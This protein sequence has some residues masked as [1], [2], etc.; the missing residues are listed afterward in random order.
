MKKIRRRRAGYASGYIPPHKRYKQIKLDARAEGAQGGF[1][2]KLGSA[3]VSMGSFVLACI[4]WPF[5]TI[6]NALGKRPRRTGPTPG[7]AQEVTPAAAYH[8]QPTQSFPAHGGIGGKLIAAALALASIAGG[9]FL[10]WAL[11][12]SDTAMTVYVTQNG[13]RH[14]IRTKAETVDAL[15]LQHTITLQEGDR[16][17]YERS[18]NLL[19]GMEINI[20]ST[21]PVAVASK[22]N[23]NI[24]R[25]R[26]G[27]V[28]D[29]LELAGI[30]YSA[31]DEI[32]RL[33]F[34][35]VQPGMVIQHIDVRTEYETV[36]QP[37][38][39]KEEVIKD[40]SQ[41][42]DYSR[43][44]V[45]GENGVKRIVRRLV[46]KD[47]ALASYE[48]MNQIVLKEAVDEVKI[49]GTKI[50]YQT[51]FTGETRE[52]RPKPTSAQIKQT[53]VATEITAYTHTGR[54]TATGKWPKI[55]YVAVNPNVIPYG[56]KLYIPGYGY[57][58]AQDTGAF[59]HEQ[60]G[61]KNQ[62]DIFLNTEKECKS[63]GRKRNIT[64]YILK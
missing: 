47:G 35:D 48:I 20:E 11:L 9:M 8:T 10:C 18:S 14:V 54:K 51:H 6:I 4:L 17:N 28:G 50:R 41:Y 16:V 55:G 24:L 39:Y 12:Y 45:A 57:C 7:I 46:Y 56:T 33:T 38:H 26:E 60:G 1:W 21:F 59:R 49:Q 5:Q 32:T 31:S 37:I 64:I 58:T 25:M 3:V 63:W 53:M 40:S 44:K 23:V 43:V 42:T 13:Y 34:E 29:A 52:W 36:D 30:Q 19:D 2:R 61:M 62:I 15:F 27:S 22:G